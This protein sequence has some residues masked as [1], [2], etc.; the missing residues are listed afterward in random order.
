MWQ[1][2]MPKDIKKYK[3]TYTRSHKY[4]LCNRKRQEKAWLLHASKHICFVTTPLPPEQVAFFLVFGHRES[5]AF[6]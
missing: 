6:S 3:N 5:D 4:K 1:A 2:L